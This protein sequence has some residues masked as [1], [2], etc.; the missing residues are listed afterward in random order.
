M[1]V[2]IYDPDTKSI[3]PHRSTQLLDLKDC[4][5]KA[6][7]RLESA[8]NESDATDKKRL[9]HQVAKLR[10]LTRILQDALDSEKNSL[11]ELDRRLQDHILGRWE[12]D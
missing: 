9:K 2:Q 10:S 3:T 8:I 12:R 6:V 11:D 4:F 5:R 7:N 1:R